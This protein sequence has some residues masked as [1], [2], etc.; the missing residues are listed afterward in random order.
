MKTVYQ[1]KPREYKPTNGGYAQKSANVRS[2][3]WPEHLI[4]V[5]VIATLLLFMYTAVSK[6]LNY[7]LFVFQMQLVPSDWLSTWAPFLGRAVPIIE[8]VLVLLL[9]LNK[10]RLWGLIGS[11]TLMLSFEAYIAWM[12]IMEIQ[13]GMRL[14]CTC[15]GI[16]SQMGWTTHLFFNGIFILLLSLSIYFLQTRKKHQTL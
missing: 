13:T 16:V 1:N 14:P 11:L 9:Y 6:L 15:G 4:T 7:D 5:T 10:T 12:K 3:N 8:L 2:R